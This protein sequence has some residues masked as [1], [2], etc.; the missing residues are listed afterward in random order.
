MRTKNNGVHTGLSARQ[1]PAAHRE[2]DQQS[3]PAI[4]DED[5][6]VSVLIHAVNGVIVAVTTAVVVVLD[7]EDEH[8]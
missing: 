1:M 3:P 2:E 5:F 4:S 6:D 7:G 8:G